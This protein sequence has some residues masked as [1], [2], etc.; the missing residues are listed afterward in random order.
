MKDIQVTAY[1]GFSKVAGETCLST[2]IS[3]IR[4]STYFLTVQKVEQQCLMGN[5][6]KANE[7]KKRL[8]FF[9]LTANYG[10]VRQPYS[11]LRYNPVITIDVDDIAE[12]RI[13]AVRQLLES[14]P[15]VLAFFLTPK[16]H[17]FKIFVYLRTSY[18]CHLR[19]ITFCVPAITYSEL[20]QHH[21]QMYEACLLYTSPSPRD[22][23]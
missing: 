4:S 3:N 14:A 1:Q 8:P 9:S 6:A 11:L 12:D 19:K 23:G 17:G 18:A 15:D 20:E 10:E 16:R 2:I 21:A 13:N 5:I 22:R 7:I